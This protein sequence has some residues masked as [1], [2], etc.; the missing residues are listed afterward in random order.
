MGTPAAQDTCRRKC[1]NGNR[2]SC[3]PTPRHRWHICSDPSCSCH[4]WNRDW[5]LWKSLSKPEKDD[6]FE[7]WSRAKQEHRAILGAPFA[8]E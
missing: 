6:W 7:L 4:N 1:E 2:C 5:G 8:E 3:D